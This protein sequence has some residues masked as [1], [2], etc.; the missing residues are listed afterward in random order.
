[1]KAFTAAEKKL[2]TERAK[3]LR[4]LAVVEHKLGTKR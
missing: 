1:M 3:L 2:I 4:Q